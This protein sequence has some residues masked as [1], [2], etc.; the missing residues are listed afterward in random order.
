MEIVFEKVPLEEYLAFFET[1]EDSDMKRWITIQHEYLLEPSWTSFNT[2]ELYCPNNISIT[3]GSEFTIP[4]GFKCVSDFKKVICIPCFNAVEDI[5]LTKDEIKKHI[6]VKGVA[7]ENHCFQN[8]DKLLK[9]KF[10]G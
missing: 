1:E 8:G 3:R 9:L 10:G 5:K 6:V 7:R 2:Y 4:T